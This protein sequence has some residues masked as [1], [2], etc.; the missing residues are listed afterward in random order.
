M[1][2]IAQGVVTVQEAEQDAP[3]CAAKNVRREFQAL[4]AI[5]E[6]QFSNAE[7]SDKADRARLSKARQAAV[8]G[9]KLSDQ[10]VQLLRARH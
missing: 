3:A 6:A 10:L 4:L 2:R 8:R 9:L 1:D 7:I 5:L